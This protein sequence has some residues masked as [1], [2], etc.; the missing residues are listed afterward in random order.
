MKFEACPELCE[1]SRWINEATCQAVRSLRFAS[2]HVLEFCYE[3]P[4][5]RVGP[6]L[7]VVL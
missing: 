7:G 5:L 1:G 3:V 4:P 6:Y 2:G